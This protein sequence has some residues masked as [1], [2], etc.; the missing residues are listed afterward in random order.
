MRPDRETVRRIALERA[1]GDQ[2][3]EKALCLLD[4]L[5]EIARHP[6]LGPRLVL[7]G[8]TALNLF[9]WQCPRLSVDIDLNYIGGI[10]TEEMQGEREDLLTTVERVCRSVGYAVRRGRDAHASRTIYLRYRSVLGT[11]DQVQLD[12]NFLMR[13]CLFQPALRSAKLVA[14]PPDIEFPVAALEEVM[15]GKL[16]ALLDRGAPRDLYDAYRFVTQSDQYDERRLRQAFV[17]FASAGLPRPLWEYSADRLSRVT[18]EQVERQLWPVLI[19][20][21]RPDIR[22]MH[23]LVS[24]LVSQLVDLREGERRFAEAVLAGELDPGPLCRGD[25]EL[26]ARIRSHPALLWKL[27]NVREWR[28]RNKQ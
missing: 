27:K 6:Y 22:N 4:L 24:P 12:I 9:H 17:V 3:V 7:K 21:N 1:F 11:E 25:H 16:V 20:G 15:A 26:E 13:V 2:T 5:G 28:G 18:K 10:S 14:G 8:G 19:E 23:D